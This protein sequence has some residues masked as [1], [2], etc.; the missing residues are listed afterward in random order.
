MDFVPPNERKVDAEG[1]QQ[2]GR[3]RTVEGVKYYLWRVGIRKYELRNEDQ[4]IRIRSNHRYSGYEISVDGT[5]VQKTFRSVRT[6]AQA[7][8]AALKE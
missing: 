5:H 7:A 1:H 2:T 4:R 8:I 3:V 6:A